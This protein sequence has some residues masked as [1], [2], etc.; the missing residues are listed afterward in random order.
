ML[1]VDVLYLFSQLSPLNF[2]INLQIPAI[3]FR[4]PKEKLIRKVRKIIIVRYC[5]YP[6]W[7]KGFS[8]AMIKERL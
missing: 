3:F 2:Y 8:F 1:V 4:K 5:I 7:H 6:D